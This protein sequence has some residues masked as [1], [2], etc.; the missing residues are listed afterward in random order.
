MNNDPFRNPTDTE[1]T[2]AES[3]LG[4][5]FHD[6]YRSFLKSHNG[7]TNEEWS[8]LSAWHKQVCVD[9]E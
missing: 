7:S 1:I 4:I 6:D 8:N 9:L 2:S 5:S 3:K